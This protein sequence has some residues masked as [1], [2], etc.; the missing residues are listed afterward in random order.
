MLKHMTNSEEQVMK[1]L[2]ESDKPLSCTEIVE[3]SPDKTWKDS[4]VHSLIKS[5]IKKNLVK[6]GSFE[7]VS[8]SYARKFSP[9]YNYNEY[10]LLSSFSD[11]D[12]RD[13]DKMIEFYQVFLSLA[14]TDRVQAYIQNRI[15]K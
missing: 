10:I 9:T 1:L 8:R 4:Y 5:L 12:L 14:G 7:L 3:L 6:I 13:A 2:W 15:E 11:D